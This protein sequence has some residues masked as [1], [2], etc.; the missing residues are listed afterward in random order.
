MLVAK[1]N[2]IQYTLNNC[3]YAVIWETDIPRVPLEILEPLRIARRRELRRFR[4]R[5]DC[6]VFFLA[7]FFHGVPSL[8]AVK[9]PFIHFVSPQSRGKRRDTSALPQELRFSHGVST[10]VHYLGRFFHTF[11]WCHKLESSVKKMPHLFLFVVTRLPFRGETFAVP[12]IFSR[13]SHRFARIV[14]QSRRRRFQVF[15]FFQATSTEWPAGDIPGQ[16]WS[17]AGRWEPI[18]SFDLTDVSPTSSL[19]KCF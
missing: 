19:T 13:L 12:N 9:P 15:R 11:S 16:W 14:I 2:N 8:V 10:K 17:V 5:Y 7:M 6:Y 18:D 4:R 1:Q 3:E